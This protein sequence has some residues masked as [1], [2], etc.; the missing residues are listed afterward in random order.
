VIE[1]VLSLLRPNDARR[2]ARTF[3]GVSSLLGTS[4]TPDIQIDRIGIELRHLI[5][6]FSNAGHRLQRAADQKLA[7]YIE[8]TLERIQAVSCRI[9]VVGQVKAGKSSFINA[10]VQRGDLLPTHVNPWTAVATKL[11]FGMPGAPV[12][13]SD[14]SF[15][16]SQEW[17]GLGKGADGI[18]ENLQAGLAE[19]KQR[20][21]VR[22][23]ESFHHLLGKTH[24]YQTVQP[25]ILQNYLCAGPPVAEMSREIKPGRYADITKS[26]NV[27]FPLPPFMMPATLV[28]TPGTND[29]TH[30][31]MRT[32]RE[33]IEEADIY[34]V[35]VTAR[36]LLSDSDL[37]LIE[38]LRGLKQ[39]RIIV[40][41]NRID[42]LDD[43][44]GRTDIVIQHVKNELGR[45]FGNVSIPVV[46]GS[47]KW[48]ALSGSRDLPLLLAEAR[49]AS[50][51]ALAAQRSIVSRP[52]GLPA[53][54]LAF[55]QQSFRF[56]SGFGSVT[57]LLSLFMLSGFLSNHARGIVDVLL[58][59]AE[60][61]TG[62]AQ[63]RLRQTAHA[64]HE[65]LDSAA[66]QHPNA[67]DRPAQFGAVETLLDQLEQ[68]SHSLK[69]ESE[70]AVKQGL[71]TI[72]TLLEQTIGTFTPPQEQRFDELG[73]GVKGAAEPNS[74][75]P[76]SPP[77]ESGPS[78][79]TTAVD[80]LASVKERTLELLRGTVSEQ[81]VEKRLEPVPTA[82]RANSLTTPVTGGRKS[83][84]IDSQVS[85]WSEWFARQG[86]SAQE[87][88]PAPQVEAAMS[89]LAGPNGLP[90]VFQRLDDI[91]RDLAPGPA[92]TQLIQTLRA[93][94]GDLERAR[95]EGK[96]P[97]GLAAEYGRDV[98]DACFAIGTHEHVTR[99]IKTLFAPP[100]GSA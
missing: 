16:T 67:A 36:Q 66:P 5:D 65:T 21:E 13:G 97:A 38:L 59:A 85:W 31:R 83:V 11:Q 30:L 95:A 17:I 58:S 40:F 15:F 46:A 74:V 12:T 33:I 88:H 89:Y 61:S 80:W 45:V 10:L 44:A 76:A 64:L 27:Y 100:G 2:Q 72:E 25:A 99:Q 20:A 93:L 43:K 69:A 71:R 26:A 7:P 41:I 63:R 4:A 81:P 35:V 34:I 84:S 47:A 42:E 68:R 3:A 78:Q 37:G 29:P 54:D 70:A 98:A 50:F 48:A 90:A 18:D 24:H 56:A 28:D 79:A 62:R 52:Q 55:L 53:D 8:E 87:A 1:D 23:G 32:T 96:V 91:L 57:K 14:F 77:P 60:A 49:V 22:L 92:L 19:M 82:A 9:A 51:A 75:I 39:K 6:A 86:A 73:G 94:L